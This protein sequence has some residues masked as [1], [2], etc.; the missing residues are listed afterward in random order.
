[1]SIAFETPRWHAPH[2]VRALTTYRQG[3][4]SQGEYA[5]L[6]LGTHVDDE[7]GA[8]MNNRH[9]LRNQLSLPAEPIWLNQVHGIEVHEILPQTAFDPHNVIDADGAFTASPQ[10]VCAILTADCLPLFLTNQRGDKVAL[11]HAGWRGLAEGIVE[12]GIAA[13]GGTPQELIVW[14]GP[15][16]GPA[17]FEVG[18]EVREQLGG[19]EACY[20]ASSN[21]GKWLADLYALVGERLVN[22]GVSN[23][24]HSKACTFRDEQL[25][26][27]H[28]RV[29]SLARDAGAVQS[30]GRMASL[31][32]IE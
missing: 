31:I 23:Y 21:S 22:Q 30:C 12:E 14:A 20:T 13:M 16:I 2:Q 4:V 15:C 17:H 1:M 28:R 9:L 18:D 8:V 25:F 26:F 19:T 29:S 11:L 24:T 5:S 32:W 10:C 3:G 27:S 6:N 7:S